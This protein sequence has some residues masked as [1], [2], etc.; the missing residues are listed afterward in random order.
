MSIFDILISQCDKQAEKLCLIEM[1]DSFLEEVNIFDSYFCQL[2]QMIESKTD[3]TEA[4]RQCIDTLLQKMNAFTCR[5]EESMDRIRSEIQS[6][7][8]SHSVR[9]YMLPTYQEPFRID[10][11][12]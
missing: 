8:R 1:D 6:V 12:Y 5:M 9:K 7:K 3:F 11:T 2:R 4:E 10:K